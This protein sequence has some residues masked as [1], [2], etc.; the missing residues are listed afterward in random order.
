MPS[1]LVTVT[2]VGV[3]GFAYLLRSV[4]GWLSPQGLGVDHWFWKIYIETYRRDRTFPP[5]LP[6]YVLDEAQWYPPL[7]PLLM[8]QL[9]AGIFDRWNHQIAILIDLCRMMLLLAAVSWLSDGSPGVLLVAGLIYATTPIQTSYNIQLN[10]RGLAAL[11]LDALLL[12]VLWA[13]Y[14]PNP[15]PAWLLAAALGAAILLTHKMTS[16]LF[17]F[18][19]VGTGIIY[20]RWQIVALIPA[21]ML[22][23]LLVSRG[24]YWKVLIA[25]WD[26]VTF[27]NRHWRWIGADPIRE[28]PVYGDGQYQRPQKL[29][30]PGLRGLTWHAV[31]LL[32]FNP[33]AWLGCTLAYE[34]IF[35]Q[36]PFLIYP[37]YLL[38]WLLLPCLFAVLTSLV[39]RLKCLGA[40]YLYIYNTSLMCSMLFALTFRYTLNPG[41]SAALTVT[42]IAINMAGLVVYYRELLGNKRTRIDETLDRLIDELGRRPHGVVM[43]LPSNWHEV[44]AYRTGHRVLWGAHGYGFRNLEPL[45]PR[46]MVSLKTV[47]ER[48]QV[49]YLLTSA[50]MVPPSLEAELRAFSCH[51]DGDYRLYCFDTSDSGSAS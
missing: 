21:S 46:L 47:I 41:F 44:V 42:A 15:W 4:P 24:F 37:T 19:A 12:T 3:L 16:Q 38:V 45:W 13:F 8:A 14:D 48:Y 50:D 40:G 2:V 31:I 9:P 39:P 49:R 17:W 30:K 6:R 1:P 51:R 29:H 7:F 25:H 5:V 36:S 34:R 18:V 35:M 26:I 28:S 23:A 43:C 22:L 27:W 33:A 32:G 11:M 20:Q 10:P